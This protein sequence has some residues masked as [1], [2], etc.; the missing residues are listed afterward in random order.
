M[1]KRVIIPLVTAVAFALGTPMS[2]Y[3]ESS[4]LQILNQQ[5]KEKEAIKSTEQKELNAISGKVAASESQLA[6]IQK[7]VANLKAKSQQAEKDQQAAKERVKQREEILKK[8]ISAMYEA[9]DDSYI[10]V[11]LGAKNFGDFVER[12]EFLK[13]IVEQD[14]QILEENKRDI[15]LIEV[16]K[17]EI[18]SSLATVREKEREYEKVARG[19]NAQKS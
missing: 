13:L 9:G 5:I 19:L 17:K 11:L 4:R 15:D 6:S 1:K 12:L 14:T 3:A 8:R 18:A 2:T 10:D 16:K 7:Q